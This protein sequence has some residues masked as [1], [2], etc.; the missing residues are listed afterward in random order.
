VHVCVC[1]Y[2]LAPEYVF[3][4]AFE[5]CVKVTKYFLINAAKFH[6]DPHRIAIAGNLSDILFIF[7]L[8]PHKEGGYAFISVH[9]SVH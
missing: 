3:P 8:P 1:S 7:L 6:V 9:L 4:A 2:R 5:D